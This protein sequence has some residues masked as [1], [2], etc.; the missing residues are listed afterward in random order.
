[1]TADS[2]ADHMEAVLDTDQEGIQGRQAAV[3]YSPAAEVGRQRIQAAVAVRS[4][5]SLDTLRLPAADNSCKG[6][7]PSA[8]VERWDRACSFALSD[9]AVPEDL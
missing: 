6:C 8:S 9:T 5:D 7:N 1:M 2:P 4:L 3:A